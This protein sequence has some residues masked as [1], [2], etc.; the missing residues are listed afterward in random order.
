MWSTCWTE[1]VRGVLPLAVATLLLQGCGTVGGSVPE[2]PGATEALVLSPAAEQRWRQALAAREVGDSGKA[3]EGFLR[4]NA[5]YPQLAGPLVN[6]AILAAED[7]D[8]AAARQLLEQAAAVCTACAPVWNE[9]GVVERREGRFAAAEQAYLKAIEADPDYPLPYFNLGVL[10]ELY[11]QRPAQA[12]NWYERYIER[13]PHLN[14]DQDVAAW[15][16]D[17][18]RRA[19]LLS[20]TEGG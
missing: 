3:R 12:A 14:C 7:E 11:W 1:A 16:T 10:Y 5:E 13:G 4:L 2:P 6:L 17:L 18:R 8:T 20:R 15:V 9:L 19:E